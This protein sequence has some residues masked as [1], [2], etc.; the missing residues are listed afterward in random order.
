MCVSVALV[1]EYEA[2]AMRLT[3]TTPLRKQGVDAV[4]D[5]ICS[6][7]RHCRV[8]FLWRPYLRDPNDD[9][10]LEL[11]VSSGAR[12]I[13]THNTRDFTGIEKSGIEAL[14]PREFLSA[15]RSGK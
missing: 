14:T 7:A 12:H 15:I 5:Y 1:M 11:A 9:M 6:E 4:L 10:V 3:S 13:I 2:A 8:H